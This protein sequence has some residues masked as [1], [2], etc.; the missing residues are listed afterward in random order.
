MT[1]SPTIVWLHR[2]FRLSDNAALCWAAQRGPVIPVYIRAPDA[3][4]GGASR[5]WLQ[6]ALRQSDADFA[7]HRVDLVLKRGEPLAILRDLIRAAGANA[8]TWARRYEPHL[9][10][11]DKRIADALSADGI[12]VKIHTGFLLFDPEDIKTKSG[13]PFRVYT[14]FSKAC[15]AAPAPLAPL[16]VPRGLRGVKDLASDKIESWALVPKTEK[17]S[18]GL[19]KAWK[20][21][22]KAAHSRLQHFLGE[23]L[24]AYKVMRDRPDVVGT[25]RMSPYLHFGHISPRQLWHALS[26]AQAHSPATSPSAERY[27]LE[28]LWREFSW[29]LIHHIPSM[30]S[31]PLQKQFAAMP[32]R[33]DAKG[34]AAWQKGLTGYPI[35]DAGMR[36][37]WQTGWM[38][39]R[40]RMIV[41]SF[42]IKDLLIDWRTGMDWFWDTLV[43][44]DLGNNTASWQWVAGCGADAA[45]YFRIFN[46]ILQGA[47][48][49]PEGDYVRA[50][51]P[52]MAKLD[53]T[54]IHE[55][56]KAPAE[57]LEK[58]GIK[59]G[60]TYPLPILD[61]GK[62]RTR[63]LSALKAAKN[64]GALE[65]ET[66]DL[67]D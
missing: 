24:S 27:L 3:N 45:P 43:D 7:A 60:K 51:V 12:D 16:P 6:E 35:I 40:V 62:A 63:A 14:P 5:W 52:E 25:S 26:H 23:N 20:A 54:Y 18:A 13:G 58:A 61:H 2:D 39:N 31:E 41:A 36:E 32:W 46:P 22:E 55:P 21:G 66:Q 50:F 59:L 48:F 28:L 19:A 44:A 49:D 29:H 37:L 15:F 33:D 11:R 34:L 9:V 10:A 17:W 4:E 64:R 1:E 65:A 47:K 42:L 56:W 67:F 57:A 8:V 38:H 30:P 53:A